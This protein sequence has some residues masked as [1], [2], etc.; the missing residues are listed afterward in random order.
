MYPNARLSN[1]FSTCIS[2]TSLPF[3]RCPICPHISFPLSQRRAAYSYIVRYLLICQ[4]IPGPPFQQQQ[5][6]WRQ[7][8]FVFCHSGSPLFSTQK[9][10]ASILANQ[11]FFFFLGALPLSYMPIIKAPSQLSDQTRSVTY[12]ILHLSTRSNYS[13]YISHKY[14]NNLYSIYF[15]LGNC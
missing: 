15:L 11:V 1:A 6:F 4:T 14:L 7:P 12:H 13:N 2:T 9:H 10:P 8:I 3:L 5:A